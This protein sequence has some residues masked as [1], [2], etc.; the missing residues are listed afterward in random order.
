M[1]VGVPD[2]FVT[3]GKPALLHEEIGYTGKAVAKRVLAAIA[4]GAGDPLPA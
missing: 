2:R 1:R 4:A 3:H